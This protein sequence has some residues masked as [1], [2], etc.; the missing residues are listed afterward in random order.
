MSVTTLKMRR[1]DAAY[2]RD[3]LWIAALIHRVSGVI[4]AVFLPFHFLVL[5]LALRGESGLDRFLL[6]T[7][8]PLVKFRKRD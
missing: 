7:K 1:H 4:L 3:A 5:S 8:Q 6:W 2:R